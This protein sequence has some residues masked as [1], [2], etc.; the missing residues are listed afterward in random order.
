[1]NCDFVLICDNNYVMPTIV[2]ITSIVANFNKND[3]PIFHIL[4]YSLSNENHTHF[5][6]IAF[7]LNVD[8]NIYDQT[9][10][11]SYN[12]KLMYVDQKSH[13]TA[14][15]LLKFEIPNIIPQDI[16]RV[17]Y[18][19]SDIIVKKDIS[20]LF[21]I[22]ILDKY[23]S[24]CYEFWKLKMAELE[25]K[26]DLV[27]TDF[28]FNSGVLLLNLVKL[29]EDRVSDRLWSNKIDLLNDKNNKSFL[30]DQDVLNNILGRD[31]IPLLFKYNCN[32]YFITDHDS[33]LLNSV[34][35]TNYANAEEIYDDAVVLHY[36]GKEDKP[37]KYNTARCRDIWDRYYQLAGY[38]VSSLKRIN[39]TTSSYEKLQKIVR[40]IKTNGLLYAFKYVKTAI[41]RRRSP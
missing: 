32:P 34:Y 20:S 38:E 11:D 21:L 12:K 24:A 37:W 18:L 13:V 29:R 19:D 40:L 30:M 7:E 9:N 23:V 36:V 8:I 27:I 39:Y 2:T 6:N 4:T 17:C 41:A 25:F 31:C 14:T 1:M 22:D 5:A 28:Y 3:K 16:E 10:N 33:K 35:G 26:K 15:A